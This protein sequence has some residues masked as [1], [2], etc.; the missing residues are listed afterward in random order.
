MSSP[1]VET[2]PYVTSYRRA[3]ITTQSGVEV[4]ITA[5]IMELNLYEDLYSNTLTGD[6]LIYEGWG[7]FDF[8]ELT[9]KEKIT[10]EFHKD[11]NSPI[12]D[13]HDFYIYAPTN[14]RRLTNTS[15]VYV[16]HFCSIEAK[17]N[18]HTRVYQPI[19]GT[20]ASAVSTLWS[21][22]GSEKKISVED[23]TGTYKFIM[24]S[25]T[26]LEG[27]NWYAG[28]SLSSESGGSMFVFFETL[29]GGFKYASIEKLIRED[30]KQEYYYNPQASSAD[31]FSKNETHIREFE[32]ITSWDSLAPID[33]F[34]TTLWNHDLIRKKPVKM[35]FE[36]LDHN[37]GFLNGGAQ[38]GVADEIKGFDIN[39][40]ERR[41]QYG[42]KVMIRNETRNIFPETKDY[43][44][45]T[46]QTKISAIRQFNM[47]KVR[48]VAFG[49]RKFSVGDTIELNILKAM[50]INDE[51]KD[52][53]EDKTLSG[54]YLV[55]AIRHIYKLND[56]QVT[57]EAVK[58][59][60]KP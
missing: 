59:T 43:Y 44:Y 16:L 17:I 38:L 48:F 4:D 55:T 22:I 11:V 30:P 3:Y 19:T 34:Y 5:G 12:A 23:T 40:R 27:I 60:K 31:L 53:A 13:I 46:L 18:E 37:K 26:P 32:V 49:T 7:G 41:D 47:L 29:N 35:R 24:P 1:V 28:R 8:M 42:S 58:D 9:G 52:E 51:T 54:K 45:Q 56:F 21:Y 50:E 33:E 10:I 14:R 25:W 15:E 36:Y 57:I 2:S 20:C 39:M 6:V